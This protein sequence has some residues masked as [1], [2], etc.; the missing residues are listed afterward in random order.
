MASS[1]RRALA[2]VAM[3]RAS[4]TMFSGSLPIS[5]IPLLLAAMRPSDIRA[6]ASLA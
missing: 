1:G 3:D 2:A 4:A 5:A 6:V